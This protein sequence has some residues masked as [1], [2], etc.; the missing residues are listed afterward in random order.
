MKE[1]VLVSISGFNTKQ[2]A[3][4]IKSLIEA[5]TDKV[6]FDKNSKNLYVYRDLAEN[7]FNQDEELWKTVCNKTITQ[8]KSR[9]PSIIDLVGI[10]D[11][12]NFYITHII[13]NNK[14]RFSEW[15]GDLN[16]QYRDKFLGVPVYELKR[17]DQNQVLFL[18]GPNIYGIPNEAE[19]MLKVD[20]D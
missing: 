18:G 11:N 8:Y 15:V 7:E 9:T 19:L 2:I 20:L 16:I 13:T 5:G 6:I 17:L 4:T 14:E 1:K 3:G 10:F 12:R